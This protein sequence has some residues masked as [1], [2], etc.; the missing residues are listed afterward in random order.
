MK[1]NNKISLLDKTIEGCIETGRLPKG[2]TLSD[3]STLIYCKQNIIENGMATTI[4]KKVCDYLIK[5]GFKS[6]EN[7]CGYM[8]TK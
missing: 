1:E 6:K 3:F 5:A 4:N 8:I 2:F 7:G